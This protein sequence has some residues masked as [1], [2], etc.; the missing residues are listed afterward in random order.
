MNDAYSQ[1]GKGPEGI[2]HC[3]QNCG[4]DGN[5]IGESCSR[6]EGCQAA[7]WC[8]KEA[9]TNQNLSKE[10]EMHKEMLWAS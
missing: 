4:T 7:I 2:G 8:Q 5:P 10:E 1:T 3:Q 6:S 9:T